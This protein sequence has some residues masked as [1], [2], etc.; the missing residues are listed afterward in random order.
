MHSLCAACP[1]APET[2]KHRGPKGRCPP[3]VCS[4]ALR[5]QAVALGL[6]TPWLAPLSVFRDNCVQASSA[7]AGAGDRVAGDQHTHPCF[8]LPRCR[9]TSKSP[10]DGICVWQLWEPLTCR[11]SL[12]TREAAVIPGLSGPSGWPTAWCQWLEGAPC[13]PG[14]VHAT[15]SNCKSCWSGSFVAGIVP[16]LQLP[17]RE[18]AA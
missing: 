13:P 18:A 9:R 14:P 7:L 12:S 11:G 10:E 15:T 4:P 3:P 6:A 16:Q 8:S 17:P 5:A 1:F 2:W